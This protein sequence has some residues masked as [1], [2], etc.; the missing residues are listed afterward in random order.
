VEESFESMNARRARDRVKK[1]PLEEPAVKAL[2]DKSPTLRAALETL[3][4]GQGGVKIE[5]WDERHSTGTNKQVRIS[6][7]AGNELGVVQHLAHEIGHAMYWHEHGG[8]PPYYSA[9]NR[10]DF[11]QGRLEDEAAAVLMSITIRQEILDATSGDRY[12]TDI[13]IIGAYEHQDKYIA[14]HN[15]YKNGEIDEATARTRIAEWWGEEDH[16]S[17]PGTYRDAAGEL[18]DQ[19]Q[20][21]RRGG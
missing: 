3:R 1:D 7:W 4:Y 19:I 21:K 12:P 10:A 14:I 17:R 6:A 16:P 9:T 8:R 5:Y 2:A 20:Q 13:G 15:Q 18:Y 11:V